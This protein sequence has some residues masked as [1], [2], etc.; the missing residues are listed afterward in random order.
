M[1]ACW[2]VPGSIRELESLQITAENKQE[3]AEHIVRLTA[4]A[5]NFSQ[6]DLE[7]VVSKASDIVGTAAISVQLAND[8]LDII[9]NLLNKTH[10]LGP[11]SSSILH[12]VERVGNQIRFPGTQLNITTATVSLNI[13]NVSLLQFWDIAFGVISYINGFTQQV[14]LNKTSPPDPVAFI[15]LPATFGSWTTRA[16]PSRIQ[17]QFYGE[18]S[19]FNDSHRRGQVLNSYVVSSSIGETSVQNLKEPVQ[20]TLRHLKP[21]ESGQRVSCVFWDFRQHRGAGG[22]N[23]SGCEVTSSSGDYT[24]CSCDHLTHFGILLDISG[25]TIDPLNLWILTLI[26][27]VGCGISSFFLGL[28]LMTYM[29]FGN[30]RQDY[31]AKILVNLCASLFLLNMA[32]LTNSWLSSFGQRGLCVAAAATL[33]YLLLSSCSWMCVEAIHMYFALVRVFNI[34]IRHYLFKF[35]LIGWGLPAAVVICVLSIDMAAY[36]PQEVKSAGPLDNFC[37]LKSG[38]AFYVSVVIYCGLVLLVNFSMSAVVLRQLR[39]MRSAQRGGSS[40][41]RLLQHLRATASLTVLL[42]L[43][44]GCGF[45]A[46]GPA[47]LPFSYLFSILNTLQGFFIFVFHCLLKENVR[48]QWRIHLCGGRLQLSQCSDWSKAKAGATIR[49]HRAGSWADSKSGSI[50]TSCTGSRKNLILPQDYE[51][52]FDF[53]NQ[54]SDQRNDWSNQW[55][56]GSDRWNGRSDGNDQWNLRSDGNIQWNGQSDGN[57]QWNGQSD[58]NIQWNGRSDGNIQWNGPVERAE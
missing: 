50:T 5:Y 10:T 21:K 31:P 44:W 57:I 49:G 4:A 33:H 19:L 14:Y 48:T 39:A 46:W 34:Y 28:I 42:G 12:L 35:C 6:H 8:L 55:N 43:T 47:Q 15:S 58:G 13:V 9:D 26:T 53:S 17:F 32:F 27:H 16:L 24:N 30:L 20:V 37:W 38:P 52:G 51:T 36:G 40:G 23:G 41:G 1:S 7:I 11:L 56:D 29:A 2:K 25:Q 18:T 22:W 54:W 3:V 45:F